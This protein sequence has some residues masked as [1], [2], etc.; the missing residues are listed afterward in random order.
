MRSKQK[1]A[2]RGVFCLSQLFDVRYLSV[3]HVDDAVAA[4]GVFAFVGDHDDGL[5]VAFVKLRDQVDDLDT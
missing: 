3:L 1:S 4:H 2:Q 5:S